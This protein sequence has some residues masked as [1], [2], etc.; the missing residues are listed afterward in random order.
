MAD[1]PTGSLDVNNR[2]IVMGLLKKIHEKG[3]TIIMVTH[4]DYVAAC[5]D[6]IVEL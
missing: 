6:V 3:K 2:D 5:A 4:D 1:E